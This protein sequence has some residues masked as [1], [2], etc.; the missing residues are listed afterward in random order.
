MNRKALI[1]LFLFIGWGILSWWWYTCKIKEVCPGQQRTD[2]AIFDKEPGRMLFFRL[3]ESEPVLNPNFAGLKT[4]FLNAVTPEDSLWSEVCD[5]LTEKNAN[6]LFHDRKA[7]LQVLFPE[8]GNRIAFLSARLSDKSAGIVNVELKVIKVASMEKELQALASQVVYHFN[9]GSSR[10][11][12]VAETEKTTATLV[13]RL[14]TL[15][16]YSLVLVGHADYVGGTEM[17]QALGLR[18][19]EAIRKSLVKEGLNKAFL[20]IES[21][22]E[23]EPV[24]D[25][26]TKEGR[27]KNRRTELKIKLN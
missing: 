7:A 4:A 27:A 12:I 20:T 18:R 16:A 10:K 15:P 25:N 23:N 19:A 9:T 5:F 24:A 13:A 8:F 6:Q 21:R 2:L 3:N 17:N 22:G 11:L 14:K 1:V 26:S